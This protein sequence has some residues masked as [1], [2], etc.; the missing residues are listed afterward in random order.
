MKKAKI[1]AFGG[2]VVAVSVVLTFL[3][4]IIP[5]ASFIAPC[6]A[7][8][9]L[10]A[11]KELFNMKNALTTFIAVAILMFLLAPK[12]TSAV[13]YTL[14]FGYY[15]ILFTEYYKIKKVALRVLAKAVL[16][17]MVGIILLALLMIFMPALKK[18]ETFYRDVFIGII[19]YNACAIFY[20]RYIF[21]A[22]NVLGERVFGLLHS[23]DKYFR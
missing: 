17:E 6:V 5:A 15:P 14:M 8:F 10:F 4:G 21:V 22:L 3:G 11:P 19:A 2:I 9:L 16:F 1:V 13:A 20:D 12:K 23:L 18:S 7:G